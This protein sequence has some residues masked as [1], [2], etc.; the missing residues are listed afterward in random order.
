MHSA[1]LIRML[2]DHDR[3]ALGILADC[4][5]TADVT[6]LREAPYPGATSAIETLRHL[7]GIAAFHT[8]RIWGH[9][10]LAARAPFDEANTLAAIRRAWEAFDAG[11]RDY[12]DGLDDAELGRTFSFT[13]PASSAARAVVRLPIG[14]IPAAPGRVAR[15]FQ[16]CNLDDLEVVHVVAHVEEGVGVGTPRSGADE[17]DGG[18]GSGEGAETQAGDA[19]AERLVALHGFFSKVVMWRRPARQSPLTLPSQQESR[20]G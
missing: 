10:P 8:A 14:E 9:D 18:D 15:G 13:R 5:E 16:G 6:A 19:G 17:A 2:F 20:D 1:E 11:F 12:L 4:L 7:T 3:W